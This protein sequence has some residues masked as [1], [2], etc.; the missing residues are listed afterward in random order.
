MLANLQ[1]HLFHFLN[2]SLH[3]DHLQHHSIHHTLLLF[4]QQSLEL[5]PLFDLHIFCEFL[6]P[7]PRKDHLKYLVT[8]RLSNNLASYLFKLIPFIRSYVESFNQ[9][10]VF[11]FLRALDQA[12]SALHNEHVNYF[13]ACRL[14]LFLVDVG[15]KDLVAVKA[16]SVCSRIE[17]PQFY[18]I[19][20]K[21][22]TVYF[23]VH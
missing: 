9:Q 23:D 7:P 16:N 3:R 19:V 15:P 13:V 8:A 4:F 10:T 20:L 14:V 6:A 22:G 11:R 12:C 18:Q 21:R 17:C 2:L 1:G 5:V